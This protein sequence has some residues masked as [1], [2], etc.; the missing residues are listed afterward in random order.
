MA[1]IHVGSRHAR[2]LDIAGAPDDWRQ[3]G[4]CATLTDPDIM[5]P[6]PHDTVAEMRAVKVCA[7]CPVTGQCQQWALKNAERHGI[8]GGMTERERAHRLSDRATECPNCRRHHFQRHWNQV[9]CLSC[10]I[11]PSASSRAER[12]PQ[13][14]P[15]EEQR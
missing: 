8:W 11:P 5:Y 10:R 15:S 6:F 4:N 1:R 12:M 2:A 3:K 14:N 7:G 13:I 9:Y